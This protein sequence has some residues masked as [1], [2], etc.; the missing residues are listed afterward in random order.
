M[1]D[2][3]I[4]K[5]IWNHLSSKELTSSDFNTWKNNI[6]NSEDIKNNVWNYL[7]DNELTTSSFDDWSKNVFNVPG[8]PIDPA[9]ETVNVGS[10]NQTVVGD[11]GSVPGSSV[12]VNQAI[13]NF[14]NRTGRKP[15]S[16]P[17]FKINYCLIY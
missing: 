9:K 2:S 5:N 17:I 8:K 11:F 4:L 10:E 16:C 1:P 3:K 12:S 14:E 15:S 7:S 6:E 13:I